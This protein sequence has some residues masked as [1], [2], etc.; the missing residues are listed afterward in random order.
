MKRFEEMADQ[1]RS[2]FPIGRRPTRGYHL[3]RIEQAHE[4]ARELAELLARCDQDQDLAIRP[5]T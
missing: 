1:V 3:G 2:G 4:Y 5:R